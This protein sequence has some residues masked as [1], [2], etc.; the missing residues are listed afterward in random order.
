MGAQNNCTVALGVALL[1]DGLNTSSDTV[2]QLSDSLTVAGGIDAALIRV[3]DVREH[4]L[5]DVC[6][7]WSRVLEGSGAIPFAEAVF[8]TNGD[9][10]GF[11]ANVFFPKAVEVFLVEG[12]KGRDSLQTAIVGAGINC[13]DWRLNGQ[14]VGAELLGLVD[15]MGSQFRIRRYTCR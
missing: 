1:N 7:G 10:I 13:V 14:E 9:S 2:V 4:W 5:Q 11:S 15:A 12:N 3:I 8:G 6:R